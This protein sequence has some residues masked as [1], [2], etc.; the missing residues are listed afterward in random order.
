MRNRM[1]AALASALGILVLSAGSVL[2]V[3]P[4]GNNGTALTLQPVQKTG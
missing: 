4:P 3:N 2:A 1:L